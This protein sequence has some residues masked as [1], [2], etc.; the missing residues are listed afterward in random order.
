MEAT[1]N[2]KLK[3][4]APYRHLFP[5][6]TGIDHLI[7]KGASV[8]D[9]VKFMPEAARRSRWMVKN[10]VNR[11]LRGLSIYNAC[12]KL[13]YFV[14]EHIKYE[15]DA[16]TKE[17]VKSARRLIADGRGD[18]DCMTNFVNACMLELGVKG[19]INRITAYDYNNFFQHIY[20]LIPNGKGRYIIMDCVWNE[21]NKEK[22]Y[23]NKED[24]NM[25]LQFLDGIGTNDNLD[26]TPTK[27]NNMDAQDLFSNN[28]DFGELGKLFKK[29][30]PEQKQR[31]KERRQKFMQKTRKVFNVLNK[32][33]PA[34]VLLRVGILASMKLNIMKVAEAIKWGYA[35]REQAKAKGM[36]M[37]KYDRIKKILEK[38][39]NIFYA[40]GGNPTNLRKAI[41]TGRGNRKHELAGVDGLSDTMPLSQLLGDVYHDELVNGM[42]GFKGFAGLEGGNGLGEPATGAA[43][44]VAT[45]A[46][47]ALAALIK[48]IGNLFPKKNKSTTTEASNGNSAEQGGGESGGGSGSSEMSEVQEE[49]SQET[50]EEAPQE[51]NFDTTNDTSQ[52]NNEDNM[53]A[54]TDDNN[55]L[56]LPEENPDLPEQSEESTNGL[57]GIGTGIK[58]F[59]LAN[60]KWINPVA[61]TVGVGTVLYLIYKHTQKNDEQ[62]EIQEDPLNRSIEGVKTHKKKRKRNHQTAL[63][64]NHKSVIQLM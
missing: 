57:A 36:D 54:V 27:Y 12:R 51:E 53:P 31:A 32:V 40:A 2:I 11:E 45:T 6:A 34:T 33:N 17:Q 39:Q 29:R 49:N 62:A 23:T 64:K 1:G 9:T 14:K 46:I 30:T 26:D 22:F 18:C 13:W 20:S 37:R 8:S 7:K 15:K 44:A 43:I 35:T 63:T 10:F 55:E 58:V 52:E 48:S 42:E 38:T 60:K 5:K 41:L 61:I 50:Q 16:K 3:S 28:E 25:E 24:H 47:G 59:Y 19:I 21:F 56:T 4:L